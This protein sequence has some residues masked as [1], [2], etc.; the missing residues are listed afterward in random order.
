MSRRLDIVTEIFDD[1]IRNGSIEA[2]L[3]HA[4]DDIAYNISIPPGTPISGKFIGK[5]GIRRYFG[6]VDSILE[7]RRINVL[8]SIEGSNK[9]VVLGDEVMCV[10]STGQEFFSDW[11][12]VVGFV[13][14]QIDRVTVI[15]DLSPLYSTCVAKS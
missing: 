3:R 4:A 15:E 8:E 14:E 6:L 5:E 1:F 7:T 13:G 12:T 10:K 11:C 2:L 9:V